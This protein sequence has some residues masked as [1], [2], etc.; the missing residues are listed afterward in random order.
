[1]RG[2]E[3]AC[4]VFKAGPRLTARCNR[5]G[6]TP[7]EQS[8]QIEAIYPIVDG[9]KADERHAVI[10]PRAPVKDDSFE[11]ALKPEESAKPAAEDESED[12]IDFGQHDEKPPA[13]A[14]PVTT[15][16]SGGDSK[17]EVKEEDRP[18]PKGEITDLLSTTGKSAPDGPLIDF[19]EDMKKAVP[20]S[21]S[22][23]P[24]P[25]GTIKRADSAEESADEFHDAEE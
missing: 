7:E 24:P 11:K 10:A 5:D 22:T 8:K 9:Q 16:K 15:E 3:R 1:M 12:L 6:K 18:K 13:A 21:S 25:V 17:S 4:H 20:P 2:R 14:P 19:H 23:A